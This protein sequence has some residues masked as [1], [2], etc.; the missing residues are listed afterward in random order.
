MFSPQ[1]EQNMATLLSSAL[2]AQ[3]EP[4]LDTPTNPMTSMARYSSISLVMG[5]IYHSLLRRVAK[6]ATN[7]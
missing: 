3:H 7:A 1:L 4:T 5:H 6:P 2:T